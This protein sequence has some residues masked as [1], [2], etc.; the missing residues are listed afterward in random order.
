MGLITLYVLNPN[1]ETGYLLFVTCVL[2]TSTLNT[3]NDVNN[4][5]CLAFDL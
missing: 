5:T 1:L 2:L 4:K 3:L